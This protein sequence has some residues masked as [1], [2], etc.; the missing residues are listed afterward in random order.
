MNVFSNFIPNKLI[1]F[2]D[3]DPPWT[4]EYFKK[5]IKW[6]NKIYA[7]YLN[8]NNESVDYITL[9][10]VIAEVS[11][12]VCKSKDDYHNQLTR[13]L[14]NPKTSSKTYWSMLKTFYNGRK[15]PLIPPLVINN[16]LEAD[17][18]RKADHFNNFF[19]SKCT[20][21]KNDSVL[22]TL[23]EHDSEARFSKISFSDDQ[24]LKILRALDINKAHGHDEISIRMLKL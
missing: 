12:L 5:N 23:L 10:N 20:P 7:Q 14:N 16:K 4:S 17:F 13:K 24:I 22:P 19:A 2:N 15:V 3:K 21:L 11:K 9:Q 6:P 1:T 18:K 8:E